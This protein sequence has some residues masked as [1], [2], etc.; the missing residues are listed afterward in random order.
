MKDGDE[1]WALLNERARILGLQLE[2]H[3]VQ[4]EV[5]AAIRDYGQPS[6]TSIVRQLIASGHIGDQLKATEAQ[7]QHLHRLRDRLSSSLAASSSRGPSVQLHGKARPRS[8]AAAAHEHLEGWCDQLAASLANLQD[9]LGSR[10]NEDKASDG[11]EDGGGGGGGGGGS[12]L[13]CL[14]AYEEER[15][16]GAQQQLFAWERPVA[17]VVGEVPE[18]LS[19]IVV[20]PG[21]AYPPAAAARLPTAP[22]SVASSGW[23]HSRQQGGATPP[24]LGGED[25][26]MAGGGGIF[27]QVAPYIEDPKTGQRFFV[28]R[29]ACLE[30][31][32]HPLFPCLPVR[33]CDRR[34][35]SAWTC[36]SP[37][38][39]H[40]DHPG[41]L[42]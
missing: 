37:P 25:G 13:D 40:P 27:W 1:D 7:L 16:S 22:G 35:S 6:P 18:E 21:R 29:H 32:T 10:G 4:A 28:A 2:S 11:G 30:Q 8:H 31:V 19:G 14:R 33:Q 41:P 26:R 42:P 39:P 20:M 38:A 3:R 36:P 9:L 5:D 12:F 23:G 24:V 15:R 34:G 17:H